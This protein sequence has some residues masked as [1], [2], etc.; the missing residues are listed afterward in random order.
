MPGVRARNG[1]VG[2]KFT[3]RTRVSASEGVFLG[4]KLHLSWGKAWH[5]CAPCGRV[6]GGDAPDAWEGL[7]CVCSIMCH[8]KSV[9]NGGGHV[10]GGHRGLAVDVLFFSSGNVLVMLV[11]FSP[12]CLS[13][14]PPCVC[15]SFSLC[16]SISALCSLSSLFT[17]PPLLPPPPLPPPSPPLSLVPGPG[18]AAE[19]SRL[20]LSELNASVTE[21]L[22]SPS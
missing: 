14:S 13:L 3:Y 4:H 18:V 6:P 19:Q 22:P 2:Q 8:G 21:S 7:M 10:F 20:I 12:S 9:V 1:T 15:L 5:R 11:F 17:D 16:L